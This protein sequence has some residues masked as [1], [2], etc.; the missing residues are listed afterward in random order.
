MDNILI[1]VRQLKEKMQQ[2]ITSY[3]ASLKIL[4]QLGAEFEGRYWASCVET[5]LEK[6]KVDYQKYQAQA[7]KAEMCGKA[8]TL[9][10]DTI[11]K[12]AGMAPMPLPN[13][14]LIGVWISQSGKIALTLAG[15]LPQPPGEVLVTYEEFL[16]IA[17]R[18]KNGLL[19]GTIVPISEDDVPGLV[20]MFAVTWKLFADLIQRCVQ[21]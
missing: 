11:L 20:Y 9:M 19:Q 1:N 12:A 17:Q 21:S 5:Y 8:V 13:P 16:E 14:Q 6:V 4:P 18:L 7:Q 3:T 2:I 15:D 10:A